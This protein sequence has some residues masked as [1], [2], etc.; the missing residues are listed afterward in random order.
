MRV[1]MLFLVG[2][3]GVIDEVKLIAHAPAFLALNVSSMSSSGV[4]DLANACDPWTL[5]FIPKPP[6]AFAKPIVMPAGASLPG[7]A[8]SNSKT[9]RSYWIPKLP[10]TSR[11]SG[12][13]EIVTDALPPAVADESLACTVVINLFPLPR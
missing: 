9:V 11:P 13:S 6:N 12:I 3:S 7:D 8:P 10:A 2:I 4:A 1:P 5:K